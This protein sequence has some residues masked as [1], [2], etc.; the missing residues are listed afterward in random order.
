[1][2]TQFWDM[3]SG[4]GSKEP[5]EQ[6]YIEAPQA[7]AEVIFYNR[8]GHSPHRVTCTCCGSDYAVDEYET[9]AEATEY[10]RNGA[11]GA[12][13]QNT[14]QYV[15]NKDVLVI[16]SKDIQESERHGDVPSQGYV[17]LE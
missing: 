14:S 15:K 8:F 2:W 16:R 13:K 11:F 3:H 12:K 10:Q 4:G 6:I 1:M 17:W 5:Y 9:L 7:E